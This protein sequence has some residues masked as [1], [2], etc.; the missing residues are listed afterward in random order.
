MDTW[1]EQLWHGLTAEQVVRLTG[2]HAQQGIEEDEVVRR[3]AKYGRNV[4]TARRGHGFLIRFLLQFHQPLVYILLAASVVTLA[5]EEFVDAA[6][7]FGV[8]LV[9]AVIGFLQ[10]AK[11]LK[12][13][14][15][16]AQTL[17]TEATV[18]RGGRKLRVNSVGIVPGD[19]VL[20]QSGDKTPADLRLLR[21]RDL[22]VAEAA[23][24]GESVPVQ[25]D[26]AVLALDVPLV[27]RKNMAYGSTLVTYGQATGVV[28][29]TGDHT[30]VGRISR[31][32]ATADDIQTPL[33]RRLARFSK[34]LLVI[35]LALAAVNFLVGV[36]RGQSV[37]E[38]FMASVALAV[39]AI[40]EGLPAA[41]TIT[42]AI[43][44]SRMAR[45]RA[46]IRKL[47]AVETLG[48][49]TVICS[50]KTG[51]LTENQMT[52]T[53]L[54][55][56]GE[57]YAATGVGYR[58]EGV[59]QAASEVGAGA[60]HLSVGDF[61]GRVAL[62]EALRAGVLCNDSQLLH[63]PAG[64]TIQGDPTEGALL[65]VA[66]KG[67]LDAPVL[68]EE[69]PRVD[70]VPFE[71]EHHYMATLHDQ[72]AERPRLV[73]AKGSVEAILQRCAAALDATGHTQ[74]LS[75][76]A[77]QTQVADLAARGLRVLAFARKELPAGT[78][79]V[80][81]ADV[82]AGLTFLGLQAMIDPP[83][84][85]AVTAVRACQSAGI[86]V[87]MITG[88]HALTAAAIASQLGLDGS[89]QPAL[90]GQAL[91]QYTDEELVD[92][93]DATAVFAR[94]A[95]EQKLRLVRA[96]QTRGHVVA[97]TGD[98]VNDAPALKQADIG[99]AM[100][101]GGTDVAR[102]AADMVL[103]DDNF[104]SIE[105][106]VEEGRGV[107][108]NLT[109]FI[110]WTLPTNV[111]EGLVIMAAVLLGTALPIAPVQILWINMMTAITLGLM[112]AFEPKEPG[113]MQRPP[114]DARTPIL[115]DKLLKRVGFVSLL[116]LL[117]S[118]GLFNWMVRFRGASLAEAQSVA[119]SMIVVGEVFYLFNCR[120]LTQSVLRLGLL[121]N[122]PAIA[123]ALGMLALQALFVHT[124]P[125]NRLF[126]TAPIGWDAWLAV[127][128]WGLA[129]YVLVEIEKFLVGHTLQGEMFQPTPRRTAGTVPHD[130]TGVS[131]V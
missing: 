80:G 116:L 65:V 92:A 103:T 114:R 83:R 124:A 98:G 130:S 78:A 64:W 9:N 32:I 54:A 85:E 39:A 62:L 47:P 74:P 35:I 51:T 88:D 4:L 97:M 55:A 16:L 123:G 11:A 91:A 5:L 106:A 69:L 30:E 121:S 111:G 71:S 21:C 25:K 18:I 128:A 17:V 52:V 34:V 12:A 129:L 115:S 33:T 46:I 72:G 104:A 110:V 29:A 44:V 107:F 99:V 45:R 31:L 89:D 118:F 76:E 73:Y 100:G 28:V 60:S 7:I 42:L 84:P 15:A 108:D 20:L 126:Q 101:K 87:K 50:D 112:L 90:T 109:K 14:E 10:E 117:G 68:R 70:S 86:R 125:M 49:T 36:A 81:H 48:S 94:V 63:D 122:K 40:P 77:V 38:I 96:L 8:V 120:S 82:A 57:R 61:H 59:I 131:A 3:Q 43:G 56:G 119:A 6:V 41:I 93:A 23:L 13:I 67:G 26:L 127:F 24:T 27:D 2:T 79:A 1:K 75:P 113:I 102:E 66:V 105:A 53:T 22:Q 19:I 95:P 37:V 58:P